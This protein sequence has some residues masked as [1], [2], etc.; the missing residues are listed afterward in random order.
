MP[1]TPAA[2]NLLF[3][4]LALQM[5]FIRRDDLIDAMYAWVW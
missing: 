2:R 5:D 3:G 1:P 4:V